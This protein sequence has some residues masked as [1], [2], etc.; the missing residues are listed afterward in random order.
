MAL[1]YYNANG[2]VDGNIPEGEECPFL[3]DCTHRT[4]NCPSKELGNV[5]VGHGFSCAL[6]R[7]RS[8]LLCRGKESE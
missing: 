7:L 5:R 2:L 1:N 4:N 6:A 3:G 8:L